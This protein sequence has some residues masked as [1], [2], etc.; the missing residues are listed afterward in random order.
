MIGSLLHT[1]RRLAARVRSL[2]QMAG[3]RWVVLGLFN[4]SGM[5]GTVVISS[6]GLL[7]PAISADFNLSSSQQGLL[8]S[9]A[10]WGNMAL[11]IPLTWWTSRYR[12]K[13]LNT[14]T[15]V[16]GALFVLL[17]AW[18]PI[19]AGL[20]AGRLLFG[21]TRI[22]AEPARALLMQQWFPPREI[23]LAN[24]FSNLI[25]GVIVGGGQIATPVLL[26]LTGNSWRG[27]LYI[28]SVLIAAL[29]LVW[30]AFG[31]ER[32]TE[33][34]RRRSVPRDVGLLRGALMHRDLWIAGFAF[35]GINMAWSAFVSF[36][37]TLMLDTY[38]VSLKWS[39]SILAMFIMIGGFSGLGLAHIVMAVD[40]RRVILQILG[41][42]MAG[43]YVG[44]TLTDSI[45]LLMA[46]SIMNG[47]AWGSWPILITVAFQLPGIR[48]R[49]VAVALSLLRV[50]VAA[51]YV[52]G[53][54]TTGFLQ[55][56]LD[57]LRLTLMMVSFAALSLTVAGILLRL[58]GE[59]TAPEGGAVS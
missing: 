47:I 8:G 1:G 14:M 2:D 23:V 42:L 40:K 6:L 54:L 58:S 21:L 26:D 36:F 57:D 12:P 48:P 15:L 38:D 43:T 24:S 35:L 37:P 17:Q 44:M 46:L 32:V 52:L 7:L 4:V 59:R 49:E 41:I 45:P 50:S 29:T 31:R 33:E 3:Y 53:P 9:A 19:F 51:G 13:L 30:V 56:Y 22:A 25:W 20:L 18:S 10:F 34:Y 55:E 27:T 5:T 39:G 28:F 16:L 11:G